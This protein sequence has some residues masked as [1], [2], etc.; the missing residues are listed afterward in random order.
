LR[1]R[2]AVIVERH[3]DEIVDTTMAAYVREIPAIA[4]ATADQL[5]LIRAATKRATLSFIQM[6]ADPDAPSRPYV[7]QA[8]AATVERAGEVFERDDITEMIDIGR[9]IVYAEARKLIEKELTMT[10]DERA[11]I[12]AALDG[13]LTEMERADEVDM[14]V[15]PDVLISW[16]SRAEAEEPDIR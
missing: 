13:F 8:R 15:T 16:L 3:I 7:Q 11:Q 14:R 12:R 4:T 1:K 6:Y 5:R 10:D 9:R 2:I